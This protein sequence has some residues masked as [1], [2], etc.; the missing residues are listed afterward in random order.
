M[1]KGPRLMETFE[2]ELTTCYKCE[3]EIEAL[4][5]QVH[6]LCDNCDTDFADWMDAQI[7][8]IDNV[9]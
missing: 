4:V 9:G 8:M 6:P 3:D 7:R 5:G 1:R 2:V